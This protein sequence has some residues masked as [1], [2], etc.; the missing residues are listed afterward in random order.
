MK[1]QYQDQWPVSIKQVTFCVKERTSR[2]NCKHLKY[3]SQTL[4]RPPP[5]QITEMT[6][7]AKVK[8]KAIP[9]FAWT[10]PESFRSLGLPYFKNI[11]TRTW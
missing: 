5:P 11:G 6:H 3:V 7:I 2:R 10:G 9:L 1:Q 4:L 8:G